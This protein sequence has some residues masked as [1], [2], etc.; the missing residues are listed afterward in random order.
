MQK[1]ISLKLLPSEAANEHSVKQYIAKSEGVKPA[2]IS[3][4]NILKR[5]I[6]A[7]GKQAWINLTIQSFIKEP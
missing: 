7:R 5:S 6:D 1:V 4:Y 3:G 2:D